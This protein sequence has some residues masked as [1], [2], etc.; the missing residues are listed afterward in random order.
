MGLGQ[1]QRAV[2]AEPSALALDVGSMYWLQA[3]GRGKSAMMVRTAF[4]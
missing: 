2:K 4:V 1:A 3:I